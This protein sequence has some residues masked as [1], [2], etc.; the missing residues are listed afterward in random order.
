MKANSLITLKKY[1]VYYDSVCTQLLFS[2]CIFA[3]SCGVFMT[4]KCL[5]IKMCATLLITMA[6]QKTGENVALWKKGCKRL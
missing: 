2:N 3:P 4:D 5:E 6:P 1:I